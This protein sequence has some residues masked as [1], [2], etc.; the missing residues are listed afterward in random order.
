MTKI[1]SLPFG[2]VLKLVKEELMESY[3][4]SNVMIQS[5]GIDEDLS[6]IYDAEND[7]CVMVWADVQPEEECFKKDCGLHPWAMWWNQNDCAF[8]TLCRWDQEDDEKDDDDDD[9]LPSNVV[10]RLDYAAQSLDSLELSPDASVDINQQLPYPV[11]NIRMAYPFKVERGS[12][13]VYKIS[14]A[15]TWGELLTETIKVFQREYEAGKAV[16]PHQL[17]DYIIERVDVHPGD[18]A[19]ICIG[20]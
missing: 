8:H 16:A 14:P 13:N 18:L 15:K 6:E 3:R 17:S 12:Y 2:T 11:T 7:C 1:E 4:T 5:I 19:T 20:S 10:A 9:E